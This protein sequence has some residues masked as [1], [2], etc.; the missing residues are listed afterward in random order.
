ML[1]GMAQDNDEAS[2][3]VTGRKEKV[4]PQLY[5]APDPGEDPEAQKAMENLA[6]L[7]LQIQNVIS[8]GNVVLNATQAVINKTR[9]FFQ[10][11]I[12]PPVTIASPCH[13]FNVLIQHVL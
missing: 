8:T 13:P 1:L 6:T 7:A 2:L 5:S 4:A 11:G 3:M 9:D 10:H 12:L